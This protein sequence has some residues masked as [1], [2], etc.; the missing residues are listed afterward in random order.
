MERD[1]LEERERKQVAS[2]EIVDCTN[3]VV[4]NRFY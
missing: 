1:L 4:I 3:L 2:K